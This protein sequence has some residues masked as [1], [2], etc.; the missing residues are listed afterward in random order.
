MHRP[1]APTWDIAHKLDEKSERMYV[2]GDDDQ[3]STAGPVRTLI[4][5]LISPVVQKF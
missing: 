2:A 4:T 3:L 1:V 5:L